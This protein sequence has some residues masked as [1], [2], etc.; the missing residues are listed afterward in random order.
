[1]GAMI[2]AKDNLGTGLDMSAFTNGVGEF[3]VM[4]EFNAGEIVPSNEYK[5]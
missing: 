3:Q 5:T 2:E 1:M 4:G